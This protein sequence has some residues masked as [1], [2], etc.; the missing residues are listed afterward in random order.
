MGEGP[1]GVM[2]LSDTKRS[3]SALPVFHGAGIASG[4]RTVCFNE[5][6]VVLGP[7]GLCTADVFSQVLDYGNIDSAKCVP[8][9]LE[10]VAT[11][12]DVLEKMRVLRHITYVGGNIVR[13]LV[14]YSSLTQP[15][16]LSKEA[17]DI[18]SQYVQVYTIVASTETNTLVQHETDREDW[19]YNLS[20]PASIMESTGDRKAISTR[21][22]SS[23][24][25]NKPS[26]RAYS[27]S[28]L[29]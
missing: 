6:V 20:P 17:G 3:F 1:S 8:V 26:F 13:L 5:T 14:W 15:G 19:Q 10:E 28:S 25:Q 22:S 12:P 24:I 18:I 16:A 11:R 2:F 21:W 9:T 29:G 27:K 23:K 7:P 4:I